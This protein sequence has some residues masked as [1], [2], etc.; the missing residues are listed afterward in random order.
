MTTDWGVFK[1]LDLFAEPVRLRTTRAKSSKHTLN[2]G[3]W[4]GM[5]MTI[6]GFIMMIS[7]FFYLLLNKMHSGTGGILSSL[8]LSNEFLPG[9]NDFYMEK[10]SFM[11]SIEVGLSGSFED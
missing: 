6:L 5:I 11:P 2:Y 3:S 1:Y 10:F 9:Q 8:E 7:Y 4:T